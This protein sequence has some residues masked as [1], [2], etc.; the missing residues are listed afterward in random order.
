MEF[1]FPRLGIVGLFPAVCP[2]HYKGWIMKL[3]CL[4]VAMG[5][6]GMQLLM[7]NTGKSQE[8][9]EVRVSL[10]LK[11]E[12]LRTAFS[13]IEQQTDFRFAYNRQLIDN[14]RDITLTRGDYTL[15]KALELM[16]A[17]THLLYRQV[18]NKIIVYRA[19][20][21][22]A[23]RTSAEMKALVAA[24]T[25]GTLKGKVTNE[26][27]EPIVGASILLSG[28]D[29]GTPAGLTGDF[30][31]AGIKPGKYTLQ[32]SA[33]GY[34]NIVR[35]ITIVDGQV[36]EMDFQLK[37]GGNALNEVVVTGY[38]RQ[39]KRDVTGAASTISAEAI[40]Q[41]PVT[42]VEGAI[43]GRVAGVSV[44]GQGG[45]GN[46]QTIR[47]R[48]VGTLG[49]NDPLYVIDGVQIRVGQANGS[50]NISNL[51]D[52]GQIES[53]TIL[54]D[55][56]LIA[57]YGAE[58]SNGVI[59]ITTKT[60]KLGAPRFDYNAYVGEEE[61][62]H[63]P[64]TITPQQQANAL[65]QSFV[66]AGQMFADYT[67]YDTSGGTV[68]LP[69]WIIEGAPGTT[70]L[71]V[72]QNSPLAAPSLYNYQNYRILKANQAGT[73]WWKAVFQPALTQNHQ[74]SISG[75]TDRSNYA[76]SMGYL[77]DQGTLLNTYF[78]RLSLRVNTQFKIKPWFRIGE[79][80]EMSY[81][82]GSTVGRGA[83]NVI[84]D[85]YALSP[86]LPKYD[87][88]GNLAGTNKA[89]VL[90]NTGNPYTG[91]VMAKGGRNYNE[92]MVGTA[93]AEFEPIKGLIY[94]NQIGFQLFP[95]EFHY[96]TPVEYQEPIPAPTNLL[97]EGGAYSTDWRWLNKLA[98]STTLNGVHKISAFV[99]YEAR[100]FLYRTYSGTTGNIGFP[101]TNTEYLGN[102]NTGTGSSYVPTV[103][104]SGDEATNVSYFGNV[105]YS[106]MGKYLAT[107]T[108]R[109]DG[110][111]K[112]GPDKQYGNFGA[113]SLGWRISQEDFMK[114][115]GWLNDLKLRASYGATG[116]DAIPT[117][118]Y[119]ATL[120]SGG[121]GDYDLAGTNTS[122]M[123]GYYPAQLGNSSLHWE[124]NVSTNVGFDAAVFNNS[125]TASFNWF[126]K[127][128]KGL[129]YQPPSSGTAGSAAS[130]YE[131]IMN[132][133]NKGLELEMG[134]NQHIGPVRF[135][136]SFNIATY[137]NKVNYID[138]LDSAFIQGGQF[139]SNGAI[140][141][142]RSTVGLPVS[143]FYG[144]VYQGLIT[145][146]AQLSSAPDESFF[147]ITKANGLG[148]VLYKDLNHDGV[149]NTQDE[150]YLGN[151]NPKF[152][153]GYNL[154]LYF[155]NFDLGILLQGVYGNKIF[156][157]ARML[158][159]LPN[160]AAAG[161]GG[162]FPA[163]LNTWSPSNPNGNL[164]IFTQGLGTNDVSPSSFFIESGS[165]MR[166]KQVQLG[167]TIP[168][169]KGI[170]R[171][172]IYVQAYNLFTFTHYSGLDPEVND[173]DP[174]NL[175]I[176]YGTA[177][178]IS[179][180]YLL[181]VNFGF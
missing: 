181:G 22:T 108:Y 60:G 170:R 102:G 148:H 142:S 90:G 91:Q 123:A 175:G 29:K 52:P 120:T 133:T 83:T 15:E 171:M 26:K 45:P 158:S 162:L 46:A 147:G 126:N 154:D 35:T 3:T 92:S 114:N 134:Y 152:T 85:L 136:M 169:L 10:E 96:Y 100:Q 109:R 125:L 130:P 93:Y 12:P 141:L 5:C 161:Q 50:Q 54:K 78:Q 16:L 8:L 11:N 39:S 34:Q 131:N 64:S 110:S 17:N 30:T 87:I 89:L 128:T 80:V 36:L 112:F 63:L 173:G 177:Y 179:K 25:G 86:L 69:Y 70:N 20:D 41:A 74:M 117:G 72:A 14:Y 180:K 157:Y 140:Y 122:S 2:T 32:V 75:A 153:Y 23:G 159:E 71:G 55:P 99:G 166:V 113:G 24:Q 174:H 151:P 44:D 66:N 94:T 13:R 76:I 124:S 172:R 143:S 1:S 95:T 38:S 33:V 135:E 47:I 127:Q 111:S 42:T 61:P 65:Y 57:L 160:G 129:L 58:G 53:I 156:N 104:G 139:G 107:G 59:V 88:A 137:R 68:A 81:S 155:D 73:N 9:N 118:A 6:T 178:P 49:N 106:Y 19:G 51:L 62:R 31:L 146:Q 101:S 27:G 56:S 67:M 37:A 98:Y 167:Y 79:N 149:I 116:N 40:E 168:H 164:P 138:G 28:A 115:I 150:T 144:Y 21:S 7:A 97:T 4:L 145:S 48:G 121:F 163:A 77:D 119:L 165:Y 43:Q 176:D 103:G 105:T 18:S 82:T 132:F 84:S